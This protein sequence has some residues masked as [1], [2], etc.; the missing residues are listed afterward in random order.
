MSK[1][2]E[3]QEAFCSKKFLGG[4]FILFLFLGELGGTPRPC[5]GQMYTLYISTKTKTSI[6]SFFFWGGGSVGITK[7][8][9]TELRSAVGLSADF[10]FFPKRISPLSSPHIP[11][12]LNAPF[13]LLFLLFLQ[14]RAVCECPQRP[15]ERHSKAR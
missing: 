7:N 4:V 11:L 10:P 6:F 12:L 15:S 2:N 13:M 9:G 5:F 8:V 14:T 1:L 3:L